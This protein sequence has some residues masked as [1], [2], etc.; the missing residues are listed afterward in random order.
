MPIPTFTIDGILPPYVGSG[1]PG[2]HAHDMTPYVVTAMEV[3]TTLGVTEARKDILRGWL[4][5]REA[6]R[7]IGFDR[8]FQWIDGSFVEDKDPRDLDVV[9]FLYRPPSIQ[10]PADLQRLL[11]ANLNLFDR[12][13]VKATYKLDF[14]PIDLN[15]SAEALV[16]QTRYFLGLFSHRRGDDLWK[17]MLEIR[18]ENVADDAAAIATLAP[19]PASAAVTGANP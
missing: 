16:S 18:L 5:H 17:G 1:G 7:A 3:V 15:G 12:A 9:A 10:D 14:F 8:G 2:G 4:R 19:A 6:L 13:R 11:M